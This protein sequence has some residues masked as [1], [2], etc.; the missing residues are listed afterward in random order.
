MQNSL[1][2]L[3]VFAIAAYIEVAIHLKLNSA[4][5]QSIKIRMIRGE[6]NQLIA[7]APGVLK[8]IANSSAKNA[9]RR[10]IFHLHETFNLQPVRC[11]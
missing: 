6:D 3:S 10:F 1:L 9:A 5:S 7:M 11:S 2:V 4:S 8:K